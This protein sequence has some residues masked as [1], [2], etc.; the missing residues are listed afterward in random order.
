MNTAGMR[1][2]SCVE[3][4][5]MVILCCAAE[6][7]WTNLNVLGTQAVPTNQ[8]EAFYLSGLRERA[9]VYRRWKHHEV[10]CSNTQL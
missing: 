1:T 9:T 8:V 10:T 3:M 5:I 6:K 7:P 4:T 2:R